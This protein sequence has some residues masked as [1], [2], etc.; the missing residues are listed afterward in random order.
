M[1]EHFAHQHEQ[2]NWRQREIDDSRRAVPEHL[3]QAGI[4]AEKQDRPDDVDRHEREGDRQADEQKH[5]GAAEKQE[6]GE[7]PR[8]I[9]LPLSVP[10]A[11]FAH[12]CG[13]PR[14]A[15]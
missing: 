14:F 12:A 7:L 10:I 11:K 2:R 13:A 9:G 5:R 6:R 15:R 4:A 8:H 3:A 1:E